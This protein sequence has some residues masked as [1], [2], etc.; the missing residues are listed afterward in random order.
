MAVTVTPVCLTKSVGKS[1]PLCLPQVLSPTPPH[2]PPAVQDHPGFP[3]PTSRR[4]HSAPRLQIGPC[5][6]PASSPTPRP[7]HSDSALPRARPGPPS[8]LPRSVAPLGGGARPGTPQAPGKPSGPLQAL[9]GDIRFP[10]KG[11]V[12]GRVDGRRGVAVQLAGGADR[13]RREALGPTPRPDAGF[14]GS[15]PR[16]RELLQARHPLRPPGRRRPCPCLPAPAGAAEPP[17]A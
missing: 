3:A 7:L 13:R 12:W 9:S 15:G 14:R 17:R 2:R 4:E 11:C 10:E 6:P 1:R 16:R 5:P 8:L